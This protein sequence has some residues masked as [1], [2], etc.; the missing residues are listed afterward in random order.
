MSENKEW[1]VVRES[2]HIYSLIIII[3]ITILFV[4][5]FVPIVCDDECADILGCLLLQSQLQATT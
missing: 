3:I 4:C 5:V 1:N 2:L